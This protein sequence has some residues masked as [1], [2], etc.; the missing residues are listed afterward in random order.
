MESYQ[1]RYRNF[2]NLAVAAVKLNDMYLF[3]RANEELKKME[4]AYPRWTGRN[5]GNYQT[6]IVNHGK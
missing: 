6:A 1:T 3:R 2:F 5:V 4:S